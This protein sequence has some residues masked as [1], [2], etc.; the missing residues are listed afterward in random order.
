MPGVLSDQVRTHVSILFGKATFSPSFFPTCGTNVTLQLHRS[1][2]HFPPASLRPCKMNIIDAEN[3]I[4]DNYQ[5]R[6]ELS[7]E[8]KIISSFLE[9]RSEVYRGLAKVQD[10]VSDSKPFHYKITLH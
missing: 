5:N 2:H 6:P 1:A 8:D 4:M 10:D 7:P 3:K 9:A